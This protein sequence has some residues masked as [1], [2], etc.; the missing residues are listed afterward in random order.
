MIR[1]NFIAILIHIFICAI[2][3]AIYNDYNEQRI[4]DIGV[5]VFLLLMLGYL[6][7]GYCLAGNMLILYNSA[8]KNFLSVI[9][10]TAVTTTIW[11]FCFIIDDG[12]MLSYMIWLFCLYGNMSF[13]PLYLIMKI[14]YS[15][16]VWT[17]LFS[18]I[19]SALIWM[20][21]EI[22]RHTKKDKLIN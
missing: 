12:S 14:Q 5:Y 15:F 7:S 16:P 22:N 8:K 3:Y 18:I 21:I 10:V 1:N 6:I 13:Y 19:P 9:S 17:I 2:A 11:L 4:K 20:G